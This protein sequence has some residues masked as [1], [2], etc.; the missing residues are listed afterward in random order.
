MIT[1]IIFWN[2]K[3]WSKRICKRCKKIKFGSIQFHPEKSG[4]I[5]LNLLKETTK[6][7]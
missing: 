2:V 4:Q 7:F 3:K 1:K 6:L 5:G